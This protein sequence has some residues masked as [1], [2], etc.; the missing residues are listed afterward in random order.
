MPMLRC[1]VG[2]VLVFVGSAGVNAYQDQ[3]DEDV[4]VMAKIKEY[5]AEIQEKESK[6]QLLQRHLD[7][8]RAELRA[9][10]QK[11]EHE[12]NNRTIGRHIQDV[13]V[14]RDVPEFRFRLA[15]KSQPANSRGVLDTVSGE[16]LLLDGREWNDVQDPPVAK[17]PFDYSPRTPPTPRV[18]SR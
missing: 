1:L 2:L 3:A 10:K 16:V 11:R 13:Q 14:R 8:T 6:L 18:Q 7:R 9:L 15:D 4:P 5:D 17:E 12:W